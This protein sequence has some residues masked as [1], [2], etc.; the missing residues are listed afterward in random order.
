M[1]QILPT[2][3]EINNH[4]L[5]DSLS[6]Q[7]KQKS[8]EKLAGNYQLLVEDLDSELDKYDSNTVSIIKEIDTKENLL[9]NI[10]RFDTPDLY[11]ET[12][13]AIET[14]ENNLVKQNSPDLYKIQSNI[15]QQKQYNETIANINN[16]DILS[17]EGNLGQNV[18]NNLA[19]VSANANHIDRSHLFVEPN[20][21]F[22]KN[23]T[24]YLSNTK[25]IDFPI[26]MFVGAEGLVNWHGREDGILKDNMDSHDVI[27]KYAQIQADTAPS[28]E[29]MT[30]YLYPNGECFCFSGNAH[31][32]AAAIQRG[33]KTIKFKGTATL[34]LMNDE[35]I[36]M[37]NHHKQSLESTGRNPK[38]TLQKLKKYFSE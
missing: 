22:D 16:G 27:N 25:A 20:R 12:K 32:V 14:L 29:D 18:L 8:R 5:Y 19:K 26:G 13:A 21:S 24:V 33:D 30:I 1:E 9:R 35:Q 15:A 6:V 2:N 4:F 10:D 11:T 31:R 23:R 34:K 38:E 17:F 28:V 3:Q 36:E 7:N 37:P